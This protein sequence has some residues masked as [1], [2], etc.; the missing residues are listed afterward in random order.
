MKELEQ[1]S[2]QEKHYAFR[3]KLREYFSPKSLTAKEPNMGFAARIKLGKAADAELADIYY[4]TV[5][6]EIK[7]VGTLPE[8]KKI[9]E[10][11][12]APDL[13]AA[14]ESNERRKYGIHDRDDL[15]GVVMEKVLS[16]EIPEDWPAEDYDNFHNN[17]ISR[18]FPELRDV[19][20]YQK[21]RKALMDP[22]KKAL[23]F[24]QASMKD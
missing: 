10:W 11:V 7:K 2:R 12:H 18:Y 20:D 16:L 8:L 19:T 9:M 24:I 4:Q 1:T 14:M 5:K 15:A 22:D 17:V 3:E 13:I 6:T 23:W 21:V